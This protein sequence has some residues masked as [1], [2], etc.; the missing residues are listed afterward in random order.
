VSKEQLRT[1]KVKP[2]FIYCSTHIIFDIKMDGK[3]TRKARM[4]AD[5]HKTR[6]TSSI[7]YSSVVSWDIVIIALTIASLNALEVSAC[8]IFNAYLNA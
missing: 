3:F 6:P 2:G 1:G 5:G 4:V 7:T 8:D